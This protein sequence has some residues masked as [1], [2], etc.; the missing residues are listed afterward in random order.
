M[1][2]SDPAAYERASVAVVDV[3]LDVQTQDRIPNVEMGD[4]RAALR[5]LGE[6]L[7]VGALVIIESTVPPGTTAKVAAPEL[8]AQVD[9]LWEDLRRRAGMIESR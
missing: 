3:G 2:T 6:R 9:R 7:P 8:E 4:F 5:T 1:A